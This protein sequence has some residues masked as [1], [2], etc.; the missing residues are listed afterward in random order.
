M[1]LTQAKLDEWTSW[2]WTNLHRGVPPAT[3]AAEMRNKHI[4]EDAIET[5]MGPAYNAETAPIDHD[6]ISKC[7]ITEKAG[8]TPG[9]K[10]LVNRKAQVFT[11]E[12]FLSPEECQKI[13]SIID[14]HLR[15]SEV[16]DNRGDRYVRTSSTCDLGDIGHPFVFEIDRKIA[17]GLGIHW[18][19]SEPNQGQKYEIGQEFK[20]HTDY[21]EPKTAEF[22]PNTGE[23]GQ[24]TWTFMIYLNST[25]EGGATR[26][27]RLE[28]LFRPKQGMAVIWNSLNPD[29]SV[30]P[31]TLHHGMKPRRGDKY[32]ITKWFREKGWGPMFENPGYSKI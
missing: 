26:F 28:K 30:N 6:A 14:Q 16:T 15:P 11:W 17:G 24:R 2:V 32:I 1:A 22:L 27:P 25:P 18:S 29:G 20:Q 5:V 4:P 31:F 19:Y 9:L 8:K 23:R 12:N 3:L 13:I 10:R 21:F 7:A